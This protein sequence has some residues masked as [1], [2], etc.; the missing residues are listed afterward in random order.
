[1]QLEIVPFRVAAYNKV[2]HQ[3]EFYDEE[4]KEDFEFISGTKMRAFAR[5]GD[6]P[7]D[8][9]MA[10]SAWKVVSDFYQGAQK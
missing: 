9:F 1:M 4:H 10:P 8:G 3:M 5:N 7:P 6:T 2:R